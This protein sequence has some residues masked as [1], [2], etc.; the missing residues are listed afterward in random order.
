MVKKLTF[1]MSRRNRQF[2]ALW[3]RRWM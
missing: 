3:S 1:E 2:L